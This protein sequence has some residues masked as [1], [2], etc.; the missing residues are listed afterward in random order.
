MKELGNPGKEPVEAFDLSIGQHRVRFEPPD[1]MRVAFRGK[2]TVQE[3]QDLVRLSVE[4][5]EKVGPLLVSVDVAGF[6][7]SGPKIREVFAKGVQHGDRFRAL[8]VWGA[9]FAVRMPFMMVLRAA[10]ALKEDVFKFPMEFVA[11]EEEA[12]RWLIERRTAS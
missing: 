6:E 12:R 3:A 7:F 1:F 4:T 8:A 9:P 5:G 11:T 2:F 10:R